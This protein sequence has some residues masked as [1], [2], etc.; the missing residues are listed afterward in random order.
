V[1]A[2]DVRRDFPRARRVSLA[3]GIGALVATS[4]GGALGSAERF[5]HAWLIAVLLWLGVAVGCL[6]VALMHQLTG[7]QWGAAIERVL[8]AAARTIPWLALAFLPIVFWLPSLYEWARP[9]RVAADP[10]LA[11]K[12]IYLNVPFFVARAVVYFVIWA[13]L[14]R[15]LDRWSVERD[16]AAHPAVTIRLRGLASVG[17]IALGLTVSFAAMD[18]VM[19]LEARWYSTVFGGLVGVGWIMTAFAFA[20]AVATLA[21][22]REPFAALLSAK[23][24]LDLGNLLM[25]FVILWTYLAFVQLLICWSGN[26][27]E[28]VSWY[29]RRL[30]GGWQG[31][32]VFLGAGRFLIPL[33]V[34]LSRAAKRSPAVMA[35]VSLFLVGTEWVNDVWLVLPSV[36]PTAFSLDWLDVAAS[37]GLGGVWLSLFF[38]LLARR[39]LVAWHDPAL[40]V[41]ELEHAA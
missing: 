18:W 25:T 9:A 17:L 33:F 29:V 28:E 32:A 26:I 34:L 41:L 16:E 2:H 19:S 5:S 13:I 23:V 30:N 27:P 8:E 3:V 10:A 24:R 38:R 37:V 14:A 40:P 31:V 20:I 1:I 22:N 4:L 15:L 11:H 7:G 6:A 12:A 39:S 36:H 35:A 21:G